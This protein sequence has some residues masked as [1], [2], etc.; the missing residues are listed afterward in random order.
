MPERRTPRP[1]YA[2]RPI[3]GFS[4][5]GWVL[6]A[7]AVTLAT[8]LI[9][10]VDLRYHLI[11]W[12]GFTFGGEFMIKFV[13]RVIFAHAIDFELQPGTAWPW[14]IIRAPKAGVG[15]VLMCAA[16]VAVTIQPQRIA[17]WLL[18]AIIAGGLLGPVAA[19][20]VPGWLW[21][22]GL[23]HAGF[24]VPIALA[25][26]GCVLLW[27]LTQTWSVLLVFATPVFLDVITA[28]YMN[29]HATSAQWYP[30]WGDR[31]IVLLSE[32]VRWLWLFLFPAV[33]IRWA[34]LARRQY[35]RSITNA[36][37][38]CGYD[39][40]GLPSNT[41][42]CPECGVALESAPTQADPATT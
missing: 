16:L 40:T 35:F 37:P 30:F 4:W 27:L 13:P 36:C 26:V 2:P 7:I 14:A 17:A 24:F 18:G 15:L 10:G 25:I 34:L 19:F 32:V 8:C 22:A 39:L 42:L 9:A 23:A 31:G 6:A 3:W 38:N 21:N 29:A 5:R 41:N 1:L 28:L 12:I 33:L 20:N 11:H